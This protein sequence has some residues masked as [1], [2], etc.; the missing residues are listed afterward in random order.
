MLDTEALR[1]RL[2]KQERSYAS[3]FFVA[4]GRYMKSSVL[5][6][7]PPNYQSLVGGVLL[8]GCCHLISASAR[9]P[10][11]AV[12]SFVTDGSRRYAEKCGVGS[13]NNLY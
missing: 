11:V 6:D 12:Q 9:P 2:S 3:S 13:S 10:C 7:L 1:E 4:M 5:N 8:M